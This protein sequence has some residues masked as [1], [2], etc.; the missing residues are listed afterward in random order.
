MNL[1]PPRTWGMLLRHAPASVLGSEA[2]LRSG[3]ARI[4]E[5]RR[6]GL[7]QPLLTRASTADGQL[8]PRSSR[9]PAPARPSVPQTRAASC[10]AAGRPTRSRMHAARFVGERSTGATLAENSG[11]GASSGVAYAGMEWRPFEERAKADSAPSAKNSSGSS[12]TSTPISLRVQP[13]RPDI[14]WK[15]R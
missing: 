8:P 14:P 10:G 2:R 1:R 13:L 5:L 15:R 6:V 4:G 9:T 12:P 11:A 3:A 7:R